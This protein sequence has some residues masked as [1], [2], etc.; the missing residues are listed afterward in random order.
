MQQHTYA[1][2]SSP[3]PLAQ[4]YQELI[5]WWHDLSDAV[6]RE[7]ALLP[8]T[9]DS[10]RFDVLVIG[11]GVAGLS[12]ALSARASGAS[13]LLLEKEASLGYGAT[14]R[15]AG[16]LSAGI[17]MGLAETL[18]GSAERTFWPQTTAILHRLIM[19]AT[20]ENSLLQ[21][22]L[23]GSLSLAES[24]NAARTLTREVKQRQ[25]EGLQAE[26]WS[27]AQV[28]AHTAGRLNTQR[29]LQAMWLPQ[30]GRIQPLTLLAHL[31][32]QAR[33]SGVQLRGEAQVIACEERNTGASRWHLTLSNGLHL[34]ANSIIHA[35]G[36]TSEANARIYALAFALDMPDTFPLFWDASPYTYADYRPGNGRLGVSGG[37]YGHAGVTKKDERYFQTLKEAAQYWLPE[38]ASQE[39]RYRWAVDLSVT[40]QMVPQLRKLGDKAPGWAIEGLGS[41]GVLPGILLGERAGKLVTEQ[42]N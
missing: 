6:R 27:A 25:A 23:T 15:N 11:G 9:I 21:A 3:L 13:V 38:L 10:S 1:D 31:A 4:T 12:A 34:Q 33:Q 41:L 30:E 42:E 17:N 14:G 29:V 28:K 36:P 22:R 2:P 5:P 20:Q 35:V 26:L 18:K 8:I 16:I 7:L 24:K 37:R 32:R 39:P 40:A 19:E